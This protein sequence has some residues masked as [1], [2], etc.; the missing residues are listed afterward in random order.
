M[1]PSGGKS[2][3]SIRAPFPVSCSSVSLLPGQV[4]T[5]PLGGSWLQVC[6]SSHRE[7]SCLASRMP[8]PPAQRRRTLS[9]GV[10]VVMGFRIA[11]ADSLGR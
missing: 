7:Q 3:G 6:S 11:T 10:E 4:F 5:P 8:F 9:V 1:F 2:L